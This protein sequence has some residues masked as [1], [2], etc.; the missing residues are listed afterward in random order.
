LNEKSINKKTNKETFTHQKLRSAYRSLKTNL[1]Y[2]FTY[3][4]YEYLEINNTT[5]SL[6]GGLFSHIKNL[7]SLHRGISKVMKIS[8]VDFYLINY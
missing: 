8:I 3:K 5:N 1:P 6:E 7:V 2:L 4:K